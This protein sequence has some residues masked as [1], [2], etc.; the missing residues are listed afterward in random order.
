MRKT[1][2]ANQICGSVW[3]NLLGENFLRKVFP[4]TPFQRLLFHFCR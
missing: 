3:E 4:Q 2:A 1:D